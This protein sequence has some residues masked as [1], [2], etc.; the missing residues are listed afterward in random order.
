ML[1][2]AAMLQ[3][4]YSTHS[5]SAVIFYPPVLLG[6]FFRHTISGISKWLA[7]FD[8]FIIAPFCLL[9]LQIKYFRTSLFFH[10]ADHSNSPYLFWL[11]KNKT[12]ITCHDV[13]AIRGALG[14]QDACCTST[15]TGILYQKWILRCLLKASKIACVSNTTLQQLEVFRLSNYSTG[16]SIR[17]VIYNGFNN[18]FESPGPEIIQKYLSEHKLSNCQYIFHVGSGLL[19]KNRS[20]LIRLLIVSEDHFRGMVVFAGTSLDD[21]MKKLIQ[22][23]KLEERVRIITKP[24]HQLLCALYAGAYAFVFPSYSEGFGWPVIEAQA[25]GTPVIASSRQ[26]MPE[27]GGEGALYANPDSIDEFADCLRK[28][29]DTQIRLSLIKKGI[30]NI[31]RFNT[32]RMISEYLD[33]F[34][35]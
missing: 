26:P 6:S 32:D 29:T 19:R 9:I 8:K 23:H 10:I 18:S 12:I 14:Y 4:Y 24:D 7:Y 30:E 13:L 25:C 21:E 5:H 3:R 16:K 33:L 2:F 35:S 34:Q 20:M 28:L 17:K 22:Q 15:R 1:R 31:Q 11:P 27:I